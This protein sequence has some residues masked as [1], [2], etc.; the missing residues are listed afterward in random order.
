MNALLKDSDERRKTIDNVSI[1]L[2]YNFL[3]TQFKIIFGI[4]NY[5][6]L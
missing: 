4:T 5:F 1:V 2:C 6:R 3:N